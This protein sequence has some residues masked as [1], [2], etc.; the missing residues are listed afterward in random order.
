MCVP[1]VYSRCTPDAR[2]RTKATYQFGADLQRKRLSFKLKIDLRR[3]SNLI[4]RF[5]FGWGLFLLFDRAACYTACSYHITVSRRVDIDGTTN[6]DPSNFRFLRTLFN[7]HQTKFRQSSGWFSLSVFAIA[8][9]RMSGFR[10]F[11][12]GTHFDRY[13]ESIQTTIVPLL[14]GDVRRAH[15]LCFN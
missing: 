14:N 6:K 11:Q 9:N 10:Q 8:P 13:F 15:A 2:F 5:L 7:E 1:G 12:R 3:V 4:N